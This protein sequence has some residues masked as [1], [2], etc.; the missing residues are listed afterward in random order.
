MLQTLPLQFLVI[1]EQRIHH[2]QRKYLPMVIIESG[3]DD[4]IILDSLFIL[5]LRS[6]RALHFLRRQL[7]FIHIGASVVVSKALVEEVL[8][9]VVVEFLFISNEL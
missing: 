8:N 2:I 1:L 3:D 9:L 6:D 7:F 4:G 5:N